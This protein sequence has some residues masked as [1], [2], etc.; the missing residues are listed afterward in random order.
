MIQ[1]RMT[2]LSNQGS[3][4]CWECTGRAWGKVNHILCSTFY[5][6]E[7]TQFHK[8]LHLCILQIGGCVDCFFP[9]LTFPFCMISITR[10]FLSAPPFYSVVECIVMKAPS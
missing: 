1:K 4:T 9:V 8:M 10:D 2:P 6:S 5:M 3:S 7:E